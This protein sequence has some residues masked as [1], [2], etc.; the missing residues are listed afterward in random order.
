MKLSSATPARKPLSAG[1]SSSSRN[2]IN[3]SN[4]DEH[5]HNNIRARSPV[6]SLD[7][8][9]SV[10]TNSA[11]NRSKNLPTSR[12]P[13]KCSLSPVCMAQQQQKQRHDHPLHMY[14]QPQMHVADYDGSKNIR[15]K[16]HQ[17]FLWNVYKSLKDTFGSVSSTYRTEGFVS[18]LCEV[19][20]RLFHAFILSVL[21]LASLIW[22]HKSK[23]IMF[24][25]FS[26]LCFTWWYV[27]YAIGP[28][29]FGLQEKSIHGGVF[30]DKLNAWGRQRL[31]ERTM[32]ELEER[33][34]RILKKRRRIEAG[35]ERDVIKLVTSPNRSMD[36]PQHVFWALHL[37]EMEEHHEELLNKWWEYIDE[38]NFNSKLSSDHV[39]QDALYS[40]SP[41]N[42]KVLP[43]PLAHENVVHRVI[44][45]GRDEMRRTMRRHDMC[46]PLHQVFVSV[47]DWNEKV[48]I[49]SV[50]ELF[51]Y[52]GVFVGEDVEQV[53]EPLHELMA[54][55]SFGGLSYV[56]HH[57][58]WAVIKDT[59]ENE[60]PKVDMSMLAFS[61]RHPAL[62]QVLQ[63]MSKQETKDRLLD[64]LSDAADILA[65]LLY[66]AIL[67]DIGQDEINKMR[68]NSG[69]IIPVTGN[70]SRWIILE[71]KCHTCEEDE[72]CLVEGDSKVVTKISRNERN[73]R[74]NYVDLNFNVK[75]S[76][77]E[78]TGSSG[79]EG[80][81]K[82]KKSMI[83][84]LHEQGCYPSW[85]C[86]RCLDYGGRGNILDCA[87]L[88]GDCYQHIMCA[89]DISGESTKIEV[90]VKV[91][92]E[93]IDSTTQPRLIPRIIHQTWFEDLT[94]DRYPDLVRLQNSWVAT[95]WDY[96]FYNDDDARS[97]IVKNYPKR[98][99]DAYDNLL[100]GAFKADFFRYLVLLVHGGVYAD[101]DVLLDST[102]DSF[103]T[104]E[105]SFFVPRDAV[106][107]ELDERFC[108]WNGF[109]GSSPGHPFL[110]RA[111]E[112]SLNLIE[113][114]AD[115]LDIEKELCQIN[116]PEFENWK[117]RFIPSLM[118]TGPCALGVAIN[119]ALERNSLTKFDLGLMKASNNGY[120]VG[121]SIDKKNLLFHILG[122]SLFT[123][124]V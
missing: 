51:W 100:P 15:S 61:P 105:L 40:G 29:Y 88:C 23:V 72:C 98:F 45:Y 13:S 112:R 89:P 116:G 41:K 43:K 2:E 46:L 107:E 70:N 96:R 79:E 16:N 56:K 99:V 85:L 67:G 37:H 38:S 6:S 14:S 114:R 80:F 50:C 62:S 11:I 113:G 74:V 7:F 87:K 25:I 53:S 91:Y 42:L 26:S 54:L 66:E 1:S 123:S 117:S 76:E 4:N 120:N 84:V 3:A 20:V 22:R 57:K 39:R 32:K 77:I 115:I 34:E 108:L 27:L 55:K 59:K 93:L 90:N 101:I 102:L 58:G 52:G 9:S 111:V 44:P 28:H 109:M 65:E 81:F 94:P 18:I 110:V 21:V 19:V 49:W 122:V 24:I 104:P 119:E 68:Q 83:D 75:V 92:S 86:S 95:G 63:N 35:L 97:V 47:P 78:R 64:R 8:M 121:S 73:A 48:A 10:T 118:L 60:T 30:G 124:L 5:I 71:E 17:T 36:I 12:L 103:V 69:S 31:R 106:G 33:R 82:H